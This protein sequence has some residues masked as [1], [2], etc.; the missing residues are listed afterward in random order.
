MFSLAQSTIPTPSATQNRIANAMKAI[1]TEWVVSSVNISGSFVQTPIKSWI[2]LIY[3][4]ELQN[5]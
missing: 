1:S 4:N 3:N 5:I 2:K